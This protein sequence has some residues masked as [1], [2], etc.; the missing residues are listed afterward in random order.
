MS[1]YFGEYVDIL[2]ELIPEPEHRGLWTSVDW[3]GY[4][5][6]YGEAAPLVEKVLGLNTGI[7]KT[8]FLNWNMHEE[9]N[10]C[11]HHP[12]LD[13]I[14]DTITDKKHM[15]ELINQCWL[16]RDWSAAY[17]LNYNSE[18]R[19][20]F[21]EIASSFDRVFNLGTGLPVEPGV[22]NWDLELRPNS[23]GILEPHGMYSEQIKRT[24]TR[25]GQA[26]PLKKGR[27]DNELK[28]DVSK[29]NWRPLQIANSPMMER[30]D[31]LLAEHNEY[32]ESSERPTYL[33]GQY[34]KEGVIRSSRVHK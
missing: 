15:W 18:P 11:E 9:A 3:R 23:S 34:I 6:R 31:C 20:Y 32:D 33:P 28:D 24:C 7:P 8:G 4:K 22:W 25:C 10:R 30:H 12:I 17:A 21:C 29:T 13:A 14:Q 1:P 27:R 5:G 26:M 19:F 2:C 16:N